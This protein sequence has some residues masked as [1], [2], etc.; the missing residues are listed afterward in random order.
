[1]KQQLLYGV[2][3]ALLVILLFFAPG[4]TIAAFLVL[5]FL[6]T[7]PQRQGKAPLIL[8]PFFRRRFNNESD[9]SNSSEVKKNETL[10]TVN[11]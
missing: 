10:Q 2:L 1:M 4:H 8:R 11:E 3:I 6:I 7:E 9:Q 5:V